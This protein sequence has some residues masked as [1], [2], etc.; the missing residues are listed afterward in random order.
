MLKLYKDLTISYFIFTFIGILSLSVSAS[1]N[2][3]AAFLLCFMGIFA[4][5]MTFNLI[6]VKRLNK[7][8]TDTYKTCNIESGLNQLYAI[9]KGRKNRKTDLII[10]IYISQLLFQIGKY[11]AVLKMLLPYD[12]DKMLKRKK[13]AFLKF[14]YYIYLLVAYSNLNRKED[15]LYYY[16]KAAAVLGDSNFKNKTECDR[17][18]RI[19]YLNIIDNPENDEEILS[20]LN[21]SLENIEIPLSDLSSRFSI[22][23]FLF[24]RGRIEE[25][26]EHIEFIKQNGG[27]TV[28]GKC[29][30]ANDFSIDFLNTVNSEP[31]E[32]NPVKIKRY[33]TI[34]V[35][36]LLTVLVVIFSIT[37]GF[38]TAKT[39]YIENTG[40]IEIVHTFDRNGNREFWTMEGM[41]EEGDQAETFFYLSYSMYS[42]LN[43]YEGCRVVY[44]DRVGGGKYFYLWVDFDEAPENIYDV[45]EFPKTEEEFYKF[46]AQKG[47]PMP[48]YKKVL[49]ISYRKK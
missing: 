16:K 18:L 11:S 47:N 31:W 33:K 34:V 7:I 26:K 44:T 41:T 9:Y 19:N 21:Q 13:D 32:P 25:A 42:F 48:R 15:A 4:T 28:Y 5:A 27:D 40:I 36:S 17:T 30:A 37:H 29:A 22:A 2:L 23:K 43:E 38:M 20:L 46:N 49:G 12:P 3:Y 14:L 1:D 35:T 24:K 8:L 39:V 10:A 6:T 45:L